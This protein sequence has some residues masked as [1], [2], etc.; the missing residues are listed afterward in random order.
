MPSWDLL[1]ALPLAD[2]TALLV[3]S[4]G[5]RLA[6]DAGATQGWHR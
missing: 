1:D 4:M 3:P 2:R 6:V 5:G